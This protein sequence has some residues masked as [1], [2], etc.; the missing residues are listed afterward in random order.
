MVSEVVIR[1]Y[2]LVFGPSLSSGLDFCGESSF[3]VRSCSPLSTLQPLYP[4]RFIEMAAL[5]AAPRNRTQPLSFHAPARSLHHDGWV[6]LPLLLKSRNKTGQMPLTPLES[7]LTDSSSRKSFRIRSYKKKV[8]AWGTPV[9]SPCSFPGHSSQVTGHGS[10]A[11]IS[12]VTS[13]WSGVLLR[14]PTHGAKMNRSAR[15]TDIGTKQ[16]RSSRCLME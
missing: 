9:G 14:L 7:A 11:S 10:Q 3:P 15:F 13:H 6:Y 5:H 2:T 16:L 8:G 12:Q 1:R 4:E